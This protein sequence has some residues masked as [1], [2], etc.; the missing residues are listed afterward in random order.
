MSFTP[1]FLDELRGRLTLSDLVGR[2]V[3][4]KRAGREFS[5]LC[6]FHNEKTPSF[7]VNDRKGFFHCFGC[8]AHGDAIGFVMQSEGL[9][10]PDAVEKLAQEAGLPLPVS[11][12]A[13]RQRNEQRDDL[14]RAV[15][16]AASWF[17][18]QLLMPGGKAALDYLNRRG[19]D[20]AAIAR[21][22]L[23]FAPDSREGL[24]AA[25]KRDGISIET[26][27]LAGL[28]IQPEDARPPYDRF[29]GRAI[30][31]ITDRRGRIIAFGGRTLDGG[32]PKYL[33]SPETPLFH[34]GN[35]LYCLDRA[36]EAAYAG[37][38]VIVAEGYMDVI[39]LHLAGFEGA[40]APL[41]TALT[42]GQIAELWKIADEPLLCF[43][44]DNAGRRAAFRAAE[45]V[46]PLLAPGKS[47]RFVTL[48]AGEDPDSLIR[49]Q[50]RDAMAAVIE[51]ARPL[52][53]VVWELETSGKAL[54][55]PERWARVRAGLRARASEIRDETVRELY[56]QHLDQRARAVLAPPSPGTGRSPRRGWTHAAQRLG[57]RRMPWA[58]EAAGVTAFDDGSA[59]RGNTH[60]L[61]LSRR[62]RM[63]LGLP[64]LRPDLLG[65]LAEEIA[66]IELTR[67]D[68]NRLRAALLAFTSDHHDSWEPDAAG[69]AE[70]NA[71][72][73]G[74]HLDREGLADHLQRA[75]L[76]AIAEVAVREA[77]RW[78]ATA[79]NSEAEAGG[80]IELWRHVAEVQTHM[81]HGPLEFQRAQQA[82]AE[83]PSDA[84]LER[85]QIIKEQMLRRLGTL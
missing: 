42:E 12:P 23:G 11:S 72:P 18:K 41:G 8:G 57:G 25:L 81:V 61:D 10:F 64:I 35:N 58:A 3:A 26:L 48:P 14:R 79:Q 52:V 38:P 39:A 62:E 13:E 66:G 75:G 55:T 51:T 5:G 33:N 44:G 85:L 70:D 77:T 17:E 22:R 19:L 2:R 47:L 45:R 59:V 34:K 24:I 74:V 9:A 50:G 69:R 73:P 32:E 84:N 71:G 15:E 60:D 46:L 56:R 20:E 78:V 1:E 4:L 63:L 80:L 27:V 65:D 16:L 68:M 30:F 6:P 29:R 43:D 76:A 37:K 7:T 28:A 82:W 53:E 36:R 67:S 21:F 83:D 31:P 49:G 54:D 40:V